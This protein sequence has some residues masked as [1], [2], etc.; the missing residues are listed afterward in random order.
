M[1]TLLNLR[2]FSRQ[3]F[4]RHE[5]TPTYHHG[6]TCDRCGRHTWEWKE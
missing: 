5:W 1:I 4:C 6:S 3:L 2:R